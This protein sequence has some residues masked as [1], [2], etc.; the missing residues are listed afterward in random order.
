MTDF[1]TEM[2]WEGEMERKEEPQQRRVHDVRAH[3]VG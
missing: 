2:R 3:E 1:P